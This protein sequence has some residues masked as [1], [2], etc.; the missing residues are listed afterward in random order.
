[1]S[2]VVIIEVVTDF[3][4]S[5]S[6][7]TKSLSEGFY[8]WLNE[9]EFDVVIAFVDHLSRTERGKLTLLDQRLPIKLTDLG[10]VE[11]EAA[12]AD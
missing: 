1:M 10:N 8:K 4:S 7:L 5:H 2:G 9:D 11:N 6:E 3:A 12:K